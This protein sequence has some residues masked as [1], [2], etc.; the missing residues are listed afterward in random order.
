MSGYYSIASRRWVSAAE[1]AAAE[2][3]ATE[4]TEPTEPTAAEGRRAEYEARA[5]AA[6]AAGDYDEARRLLDEMRRGH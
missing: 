4:P 3:A 6:A 5:D 2:R 1:V